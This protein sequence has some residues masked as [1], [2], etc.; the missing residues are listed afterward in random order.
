MKYELNER[1]LFSQIIPEWVA[2]FRNYLGKDACAWNC[3]E[4]EHI[5]DYRCPVI[6]GS[7]TSINC[8]P[9]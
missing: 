2:G 9:A 4:R 1:I 8:G 3:N 6:H 5:K 7:G